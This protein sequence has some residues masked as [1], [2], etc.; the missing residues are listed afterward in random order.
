[1]PDTVL[2]TKLF[3]PPLRPNLV[4][5]PHLIE[6]LNQGHQLGHKLTLI[7]APAGFGKSTLAGEWVGNLRLETDTESHPVHKIA[8]LAL[9]DGDNDPARF[10]TY[11]IAAL[12]QADWAKTAVGKGALAM[13]QSPTPPAAE[14]VLTSLI[15]EIASLSSKIILVLDDYH[16]HRLISG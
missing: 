16:H 4:P 1:M 9:D 10:L 11:L 6:R 3:I 8:W 12:N 13:L 14:V 2:R 7:S 15:N 5:R